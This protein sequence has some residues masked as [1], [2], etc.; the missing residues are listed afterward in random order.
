MTPRVLPTEFVR[1]MG[2]TPS[3][4]SQALDQALEGGV[5]QVREHEQIACARFP[6]GELWLKWSTLPSRRLAL[7][8]IPRL[9]VQFEY[10]GLTEARRYDVQRH[11][12]L[13][14]QRGGG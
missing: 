6:D 13:V 10:Y 8:E 9:K 5:L 14:F 7:L 11:F 4:F 1:D 3:E 12:D 2:L